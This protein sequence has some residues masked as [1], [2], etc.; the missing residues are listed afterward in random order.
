MVSRT[1]PEVREPQPAPP[2]LM[3]TDAPIGDSIGVGLFHK[4]APIPARIT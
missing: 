2:P 1:D 4:K 3:L